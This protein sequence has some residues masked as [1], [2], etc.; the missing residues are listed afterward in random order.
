MRAVPELKPQFDTAAHA[1]DALQKFGK[2]SP[3]YAPTAVPKLFF[4]S[5]PLA[6]RALIISARSLGQKDPEGLRHGSDAGR[7]GKGR[8]Y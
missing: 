1:A 3:K 8:R 4:A 2:F 7:G 5:G 6:R